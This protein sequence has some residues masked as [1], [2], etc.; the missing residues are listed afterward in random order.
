MEA[1]PTT[2]P[3]SSSRSRP[4]H[5]PS[6][7]VSIE[8]QFMAAM[9]RSGMPFLPNDIIADG[10]LHRFSTNGKPGDGAGWYVLFPDGIP[11]GSY[12]DF[13]SG[14]EGKF[15]SREESSLSAAEQQ[16]HR[17]RMAEAQLL[18]KE[19]EHRRQLEV[20]IWSSDLWPTLSPA[21]A[22]HP[23]L[24]HKGVLPLGVRVYR[25]DLV[26]RGVKVDGAVV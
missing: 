5:R 11:A 15:C 12:K 13:R 18:R 21:P 16:A 2:E 19:E 22:D 17:R 25:G 6:P 14:I 8:E 10:K 1:N 3:R 20:A 24:K 9:A 7:A 26:I 23:Y 4:S